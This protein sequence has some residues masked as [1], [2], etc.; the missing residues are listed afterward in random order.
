MRGLF[1]S[2]TDTGVGKTALM[3]VLLT[4]GRLAGVNWMAAKP[5]QT[6]VRPLRGRPS[7]PVGDLAFV[8]RAAGWHP[9]A[10]WLPHLQ[11]YVL[12][13]RSSPHRAAE[14][15][16]VRIRL[17]RIVR[18][19][20]LMSRFADGLIVE[21]AGGL[22]VPLDR[23]RTMLDLI[24]ESGLPVLLAIRPGLG[25]LNHTL[26]SAEALARR[27]LRLLGCVAVKSTPGSWTP[28]MLHNLDT[29][30]QRGV[31]VLGRLPYMCRFA[32]APR[33]TVLRV[34]RLPMLRWVY[35]LLA[36]AVRER[37]NRVPGGARM[38]S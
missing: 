18:G 8:T 9:A 11:P 30:R 28:L 32:R 25:T 36:C 12:P 31:P 15:A 7:R 3:A 17:S 34:L 2:G 38:R 23:S 35:P 4:A 24:A 33:A 22:L 10:E 14:L 16:G 37:L 26:L 5:V 6:G 20:C 29:L 27:D 13:S 1:I 19:L 21:G